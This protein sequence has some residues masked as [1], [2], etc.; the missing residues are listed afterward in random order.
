[1]F[2]TDF[3]KYIYKIKMYLIKIYSKHNK[4]IKMTVFFYILELIYSSNGK[5][6]F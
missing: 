4:K 2:L 6:E 1:M 5:S 3:K